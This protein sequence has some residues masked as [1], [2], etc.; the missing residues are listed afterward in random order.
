M[1]VEHMDEYKLLIHILEL[2][3]RNGTRHDHI[4]FD[5]NNDL[6]ENLYRDCGVRCTV[7]DLKIITDCCYTRG[8]VTHTSIGNGKYIQ[9]Q[10]TTKGMGVAYSKRK[11]DDLKKNRT[12]LKKT[13]D[14]IDDHKGLFVLLGALIAISSL[15]IPLIFKLLKNG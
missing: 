5:V 6:V 12:R 3:E 9:L 14:Y 7:E 10:L 1:L 15:I 2:C 11:S 4:Y 13:S 8:W